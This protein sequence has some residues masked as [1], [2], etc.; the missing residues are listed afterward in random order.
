[1]CIHPLSKS[2]GQHI[3]PATLNSQ[4]MSKP[5]PTGLVSLC[6]SSVPLTGDL[7]G[8]LTQKLG[9]L[10]GDRQAQVKAASMPQNSHDMSI[11]TAGPHPPLDPTCAG[12]RGL[13]T[14]KE[15]Q[16]TRGESSN[17]QGIYK[18][19]VAWTY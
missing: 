4:C 11:H 17:F 9:G 19:L 3:V 5:L 2:P 10:C 12:V 1:M 16:A 6:D 8:G 7:P 13:K 14:P 18:D 15:T